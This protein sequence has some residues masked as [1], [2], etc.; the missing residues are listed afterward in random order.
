[1]SP[2]RSLAIFDFDNTLTTR[3]TLPMFIRFVNG[4][5]K[6]IN[7]LLRLLPTLILYKFHF[8]P[9]QKAKEMVLTY[10]FGG[11][12]AEVFINHGK[13]FQRKILPGMLRKEAITALNRHKDRGDDIIV[14]TASAEEWVKD[15]CMQQGISCIATQIEKKD[16]KI[17]GRII[18][19]NCY[20]EEKLRRLKEKIKLDLYNEIHVYGDS[21]GDKALL[22]IA[23]H[24]H[25][26]TF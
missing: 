13:A 24:P 2:T 25:F 1:M 17:T 6:F 20:G 4:N 16:D 9:N 14:I 7:G 10:F 3:D 8:I 21:K 11:M 26:K 5:K 15:W 23:T 19:K 22:Q 12:E 18:G